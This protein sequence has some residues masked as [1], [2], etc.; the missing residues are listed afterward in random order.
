MTWF[1]PPGMLSWRAI[2]FADVFLYFLFCNIFNGRPHSKSNSGTTDTNPEN[3]VKI[4]SVTER[5]FTK[6]S[7]LVELCK[8]LINPALIWQSLKERCHGNQLKSQKRRFRGKILIVTLPFWNIETPM[9]NLEAHW[10]WLHRAY[11]FGEVR[12]SNFRE[13]FA[14][15]CTRVKKIAIMHIS[16]RLSQK[17]LDQSWPNF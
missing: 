2:Y 11:K 16:S 1:I 8:G 12:C 4:R 15:F 17:M 9:N 5:I 10:M 7:R 3:L 6:F 13:S 14:Y